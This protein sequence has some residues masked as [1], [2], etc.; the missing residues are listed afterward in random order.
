M[1]HEVFPLR[2]RIGVTSDGST[3]L[4]VR[5][6]PVEEGWLWLLSHYAVEDETTGLTSIRVFIESGSFAYLLE[7]QISP[8]AAT[9]YDGDKFNVL[10]ENDRVVA[11]FSGSTNNDLLRLYVHGVMLPPGTSFTPELIAALYGGRRNA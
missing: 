6:D 5:T 9:L 3:L 8:L 2:E 10:G 4:D 7:E 11:R 1:P